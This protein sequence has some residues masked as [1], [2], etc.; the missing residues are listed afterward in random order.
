[1]HLTITNNTEA[2]IYTYSNCGEPPVWR[3]NGNEVDHVVFRITENW[4]PAGHLPVGE[5]WSCTWDQQAYEPHLP[6]SGNVPPGTYQLRL[7]YYLRDP[8]ELPRGEG[9]PALLTVSR[10][11]VIGEP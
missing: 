10:P 9:D 3:A 11:F 1:M 6:D 8:E 5:S 2:P 4:V 7:Y